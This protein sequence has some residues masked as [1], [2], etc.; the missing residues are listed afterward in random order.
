MPNTSKIEFER[1]LWVFYN[2][3]VTIHASFSLPLIFS[4]R[5]YSLYD[6]NVEE[7][8][9]VLKLANQWEFVEVKALAIRELQTLPMDPVPRILLY[10]KYAVNEDHLHKAFTE[11]TIQDEFPNADE[12][13]QLGLET[14]V[15]LANARERAR[16]PVSPGN[17]SG[18]LRSPVTHTRPQVDDI[19][20]DAFHVTT[21]STVPRTPTTGRQNTHA[22]AD[23]DSTQSSPQSDESDSFFHNLSEGGFI[24][25]PL[26]PLL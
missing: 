6:A 21:S 24:D 2:P 22:L 13:R 7:W 17:R 25:S 8:T 15:Q 5:R 14:V 23:S 18:E 9:T 10:R 19:V 20:K 11:L 1:L 3:Y 16:A 26:S 12:A 4:C